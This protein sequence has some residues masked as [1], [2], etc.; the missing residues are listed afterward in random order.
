MTY[1]IV[2]YGDPVLR[3]PAKPVEKIDDEVRQLAR[4]ML[5]T[6]YANHGVGL[7]AEQVGR[8]ESICVID[9]PPEE[10]DR[11]IHVDMPLVLINPEVLETSGTQS[12]PEGCLSFPDICVTVSRPDRVKVRFLDLDGQQREVEAEG[13]LSRAIQ[14]ESEHLRGELL[15]D[16]M[17][18]VQKVSVSGKLK[19]LKKAV[20]RSS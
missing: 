7:A 2:T 12:G 17:S 11:E 14:H 6:M 1:E 8:T 13:L 3:Q 10:R 18:P 5:Q 16:H 20:S 19:R 4:D 9:I 15:V